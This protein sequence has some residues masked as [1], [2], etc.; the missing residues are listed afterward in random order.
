ME[1]PYRKWVFKNHLELG[2]LSE[3]SFTQ[4]SGDSC[5]ITQQLVVQKF[6]KSHKDTVPSSSPDGPVNF[7][8]FST[9]TVF[10]L[11][12]LPFHSASLYWP[13]PLCW[14]V[15][16]CCD[17]SD[18][19]CSA[20]TSACVQSWGVKLWLK[21]FSWK[22]TCS[23]SSPNDSTLSFFCNITHHTR[24]IFLLSDLSQYLPAHQERGSLREVPMTEASGGPYCAVKSV[25]FWKEG[26]HGDPLLN[27]PSGSPRTEMNL[28]LFLT[29]FPFLRFEL[30]KMLPEIP[31]TRS[32]FAAGAFA[33]PLLRLS[34]YIILFLFNLSLSIPE[35]F[36]SPPASSAANPR[37]F[38]LKSA[39]SWVLYSYQ[40]GAAWLILQCL[41][42]S[43]GSCFLM[44][45]L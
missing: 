35:L 6:W 23:P 7:F 41:F 26:S 14:S 32:V 19:W 22:D 44:G 5:C 2:C 29:E 37:A 15:I 8:Q 18:L 31:V 17:P 21:P 40:E 38:Y 16:I 27:F 30:I 1:E 10:S 24:C 42:C 25:W 33:L 9:P 34:N 20:T 43:S 39:N 3:F 28:W 13:R 45:D 11:L 4:W 36:S 12:V